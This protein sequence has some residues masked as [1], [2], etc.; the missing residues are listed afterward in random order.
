MAAAE[1]AVLSFCHTE[2][3]S[4]RVTPLLAEK[5]PSEYLVLMATAVPKGP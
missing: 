1:A 2:D 3:F 4:P 5:R